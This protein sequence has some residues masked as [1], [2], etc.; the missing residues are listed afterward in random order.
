M[1]KTDQIRFYDDEPVDFRVYIKI[2]I[3]YSTLQH[4]SVFRTKVMVRKSHKGLCGGACDAYLEGF[5]EKKG[6]VREKVAVSW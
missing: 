3:A 4:V 6:M 5:C 2:L 1:F